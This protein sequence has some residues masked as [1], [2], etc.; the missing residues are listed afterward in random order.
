MKKK[1]KVHL[2]KAADSVRHPDLMKEIRVLISQ[3]A[4]SVKKKWNRCLPLADYIV[5]RWEKAK[6]L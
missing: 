4:T 5:D 2:K 6:F 3:E 1:V